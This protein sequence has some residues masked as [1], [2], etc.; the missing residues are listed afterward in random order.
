[1]LKKYKVGLLYRMNGWMK[2]DDGAYQIERI[3]M[4]SYEDRMKGAWA[5]DTKG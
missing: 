1:M 3:P 4:H 5:L 2:L